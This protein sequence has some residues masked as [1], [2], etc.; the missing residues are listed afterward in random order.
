VMGSKWCGREVVWLDSHVVLPR[1]CVYRHFGAEVTKLE[2]EI[3]ATIDAQSVIGVF[4]KG[5]GEGLALCS[6]VDVS[7]PKGIGGTCGW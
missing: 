3:A 1:N 6:A 5:F 7:D 2:G 4:G